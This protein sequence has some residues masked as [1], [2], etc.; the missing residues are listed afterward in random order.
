MERQAGK[1]SSK[2]T[3]LDD[4]VCGRDGFEMFFD[5]LNH[6]FGDG[7]INLPGNLFLITKDAPERAG[8]HRDKN[9]YGE[10]SQLHFAKN[11]SNDSI[12]LPKI[13]YI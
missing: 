1:S 13:S 5:N 12:L 8:L 7:N 3:K 2:K 6:I 4:A 9:R 11:N 10:M